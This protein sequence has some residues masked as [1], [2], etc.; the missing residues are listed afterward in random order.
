[1]RAAFAVPGTFFPH[2]LIDEVLPTV[3]GSEWQLLTVIV[4]QTLGWH[5]PS[6][7]ARKKSDWLS[8]RQLKARTG[9][10]SEAVS[11]AV[12]GLV[13]KALIEV[14]D[15]LG[16]LMATSDQRRRSCS[17]LFYSLTP[18]I[19]ARCQAQQRPTPRG[20]SVPVSPTGKAETTKE[21]RTK[22]RRATFAKAK[23]NE[24][25]RC[26][27]LLPATQREDKD[28]GI[29]TPSSPAPPDQ[30]HLPL[31]LQAGEPQVPPG[32][33]LP[34]V[35][36]YQERLGAHHLLGHSR[37]ETISLN[38]GEQVQLQAALARYG[39][40]PMEQFREE[41]LGNPSVLL[42]RHGYSLAAFLEV[43]PILTVLRSQPTSPALRPVQ[44]IDPQESDPGVSLPVARTESRLRRSR[45]A[46]LDAS[47]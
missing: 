43:L 44:E 24:A 32:D 4:R 13:R 21:T 31:H 1:M 18:Q 8:H 36:S 35:L 6:T 29:L 3:S 39:V 17:R 11:H 2:V 47:Y 38:A 12:D 37:E 27:T 42:H 5:D 10:G 16:R 45:E 26:L 30:A 46:R 25:N 14:R 23:S 15:D 33:L 20:A 41:F 40:K 9:R 22:L 28:K 7:G 34:F 19:L